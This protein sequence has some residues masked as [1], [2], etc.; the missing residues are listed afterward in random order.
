M[1]RALIQH[2]ELEPY[3]ADFFEDEVSGYM[4]AHGFY[5]LNDEDLEDDGHPFTLTVE[6]GGQWVDFDDSACGLCEE[7]AEREILA[8]LRPQLD[9]LRAMLEDHSAY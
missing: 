4:E 3:A 7:T 9:E 6:L 5:W 2:V 1:K 8:R